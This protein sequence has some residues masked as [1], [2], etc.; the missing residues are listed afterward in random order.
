MA[1][2]RLGV[3]LWVCVCVLGGVAGTCPP[4]AYGY[5]CSYQCHCPQVSCDATSCC[6]PTICSRGWSGPT[7]QQQNVAFHRTTSASSVYMA[8]S[9]AVDGDTRGNLYDGSC[10][11][12]A[13]YTDPNITSAWWRV[14]LEQHTLVHD[15]IIYFRTDYQYRRNGIQ[16]YI[17]DTAA[18]PTDGVNCYNVTGNINGTDIPDVLSVT[19]SGKG[20]YLVL[21]TTTVNNDN[22]NVP[23][24]DFC[25]VEVHVCG[26]GTFGADCDNYCF[27]EGDVC[28]YVTGVCPSGVCLPGWQTQ[29]CYIA[30][31]PGTFGTNCSN[32]CHCVG[33]TCDH[34]TGVCPSGVCTPGWQTETCDT[35]CDPGTFGTNCSNSCHCVGETCDHV[36]GICPSRVCLPGWQTET[37]DTVC[38]FGSYGSDCSEACSSRQC[39]GDNSRCHHVAGECVEGCKTGR[40]GADC[41]QV[42]ELKTHDPLVL[43]S[44]SLV[45]G[46]VV[47]VV[48]TLLLAGG[49]LL[50]LLRTGRLTWMHG[51]VKEGESQDK[52]HTNIPQ[53]LD[54]YTSVSELSHTDGDFNNY[55][56]LDAGTRTVDK[57]YDVIQN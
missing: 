50:Y 31:D 47:G 2:H 5:N 17:A 25:E 22:V 10:F 45:I 37:C 8:S 11:H 44:I 21:Y 39:K 20:R 14:D 35:A 34:V 9:R 29:T 18:S 30:C 33:E 52:A 48:L 6:Q 13:A 1:D 4:G 26:P 57:L 24:M 43:D 32:S 3:L 23:I 49:V 15:V 28:N 54:I 46:V 42:S 51:P 19:C 41:T 40:D 38:D 53:P 36:T 27:C 7:C 56:G 12:S 55:T 16:I